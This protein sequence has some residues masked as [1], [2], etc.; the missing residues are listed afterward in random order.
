MDT[1]SKSWVTTPWGKAH[2]VER[3]TLRQQ[4]A[5]KRFSS[6]VELLRTERGELLVRFAYTTDGVVRRGPVTLRGRDLERLR[7]DLGSTPELAATL[8]IGGA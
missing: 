1:S 5:E 6:L 7:R 2:S 3:V 8:G 4:A